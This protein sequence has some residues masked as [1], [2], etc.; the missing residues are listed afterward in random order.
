M[1]KTIAQHLLASVRSTAPVTLTTTA[2]ATN[3]VSL[4]R[5]FKALAGAGQ[6][7][8]PSYTD[9]MIKLA[10]AALQKHPNL[11]A[12]WAEDR[13]VLSEGIHV[14]FAVDTEAG[15][16]VPVIRD[17]PLLSLKEVTAR[18]TELT[19]RAR[20]RKLAAAEMQRGTFTVT[21]LGSF[22]IDA[23]TP[24]IHFPQC[25]VL[26]V[27]RIERRP[28]VKDDLIVARDQLTLSLTFDHR[29]IDGAPAARFLQLLSQFVE[30]PGPCLAS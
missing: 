16:F 28:V 20:Q 18:S 19:Q 21:N 5:Q 29:L 6:A 30:N 8:V 4:R 3:L 22:G 24:I 7:A 10:A 14:G 15:L 23:F 13:I 11:N 17:V 26:G 1:R 9:F 2:D 25:A 12:C 27:G